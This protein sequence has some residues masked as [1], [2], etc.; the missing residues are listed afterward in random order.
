MQPAVRDLARAAFLFRDSGREGDAVSRDVVRALPDHLEEGAFGSV[1]V[2]WVAPPMGTGRRRCAGGS[3]AAAATRGCSTTARATRSHTRPTG[4]ATTSAAEPEA[5]AST[6][7]R[8]LAYF[9]RLGIEG[10]ATGAVILR[11]RAGV[12][13]TRADR[14]PADRLQPAG[15]QIER[16]F[17]AGDVLSAM[18]DERE[19][20]AERVG[21]APLAVLEQ[22]VVLG[23]GE[24][25][26][27]G[28]VLRL[29]EGLGF[30]ASLDAATAGM[31]AS[32]DGRRTIGD[33][34]GDMRGSKKRAETPSSR[35][36]SRSSRSC[37]R[38]GSSNCAGRA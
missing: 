35:P 19:L 23:D 25:D 24:W 1:L 8:W 33:I 18:R 7:D 3:P 11:R 22:H 34:V 5:F 27:G 9:D 17:A 2:S 6:L 16:V 26:S 30:E 32:L 29:D 36:R 15:A 12:N 37:S 14:I 31:L 28:A 13:W 38:R 20:L 10:I 4:S 21:L